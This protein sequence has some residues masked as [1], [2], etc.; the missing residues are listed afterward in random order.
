MILFG[1]REEIKAANLN[2]T[3]EPF[4]VM[5]IQY[6]HNIKRRINTEEKAKVVAGFCFPH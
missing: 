5:V 4:M 2:A 6:I 3:L 1:E